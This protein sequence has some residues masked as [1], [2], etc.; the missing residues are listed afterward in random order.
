CFALDGE[1]QFHAI[2]TQGHQCVIASPSTIAPALIALGATADVVGPNGRRTLALANFYRSPSNNNERE[3]NLT[4]NE[5][6]ASVSIPVRGLSNAS[7]EVKQKMGIDWPLVQC[8]VS[9]AVNG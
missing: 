6:V 4:A 2:F 7:Y 9:F 1:N 8:S 3:H 5:M